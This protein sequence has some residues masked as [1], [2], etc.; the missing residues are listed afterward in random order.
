MRRVESNLT[1][2]RELSSSKKGGF[3]TFQV[4]SEESFEGRGMGP[5][6]GVGVI[7]EGLTTSPIGRPCLGRSQPISPGMLRSWGWDFKTSGKSA[8]PR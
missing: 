4:L 2:P 7:W 1:I 5:S 6:K 8:G 3:L